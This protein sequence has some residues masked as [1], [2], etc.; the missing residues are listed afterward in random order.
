M[1]RIKGNIMPIESVSVN[2]AKRPV[3]AASAK[4]EKTEPRC[5]K[6]I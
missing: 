3:P 1:C 6:V 5:L 2:N 4:Q